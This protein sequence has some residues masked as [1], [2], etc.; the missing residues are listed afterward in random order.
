MRTICRVFQNSLLFRLLDRPPYQTS[1]VDKRENGYYDERCITHLI[2]NY[3]SLQ[4]ILAI[5][6]KIF[7]EDKLLHEMKT[8]VGYV[9]SCLLLQ[10]SWRSLPAT[11]E[12]AG[13]VMSHQTMHINPGLE[14]IWVYLDVQINIDRACEKL[15]AWQ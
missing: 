11:F 1:L 5:P 9:Q 10:S 14:K 8:A 3:R 6:S 2:R 4:P 7:Y 12:Y 15:R 13:A